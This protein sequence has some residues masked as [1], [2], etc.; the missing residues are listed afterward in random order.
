MSDDNVKDFQAAA[1]RDM[2]GGELHQA[3][4]EVLFG[5]K[6]G[7]VTWAAMI[8]ILEVLKVEVMEEAGV[9]KK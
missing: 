6:S 1:G 2:R 9:I 3:L 7:G 4:G 8:G 5:E